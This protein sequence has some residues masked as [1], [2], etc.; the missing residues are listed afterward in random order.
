ML[1]V[2][3]GTLDSAFEKKP[4]AHTFVRDRAQWE[5]IRDALPQF[6]EWADSATLVQAGSRQPRAN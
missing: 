2:R 6:E 3:L 5:P 1:R 4:R